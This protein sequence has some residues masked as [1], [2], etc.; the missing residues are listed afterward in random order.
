MESKFIAQYRYPAMLVALT[1]FMVICMEISHPFFFL[2]DDNRTLYLPF[3]LH[4][5]RSLLEGEFPFYNFHQYLGTPVTIQYAALYPVNYLA[6]GLSK[7]LLGNYFAAMEFIAIFHLIVAAIGFFRLLRFFELEEASCFFG[8]V[9]WT[10]CGFVISVGNSWIQTLGF[11]AYLP[12][13][14]LFSIRQIYRFD[15]RCF[16]ILAGLKVCEMFL[17]YPQLFVYTMTFE[18]LT[19]MMLFV[20]NKK[21][22]FDSKDAGVSVEVSRQPSFIKFMISFV[23]NYACVFIIALPLIV[24]TLYQTGVSASRKQLL[25]W[26]EYA[27]YSYN[28]K[29]WFNGLV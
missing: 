9:A 7:L 29:Y 14:L 2:Q 24:Q 6:L 25:S 23:A 4:N 19:V 16:L 3:Y 12:W 18:F 17:G 5:F 1:L 28:L 13:I 11:A 27:A 15:I 22:V 8:A 20:I 21:N 10:F 26:E